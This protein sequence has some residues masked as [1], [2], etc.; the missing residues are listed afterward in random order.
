MRGY[1]LPL[2]SPKAPYMTEPVERDGGGHFVSGVSGNPAGRPR[3][4]GKTA[5]AAAI[6]AAL[7]SEAIKRNVVV[8]RSFNPDRYSDRDLKALIRAL[9]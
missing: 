1:P 9:R 2:N 3:G 7:R 5:K 8:D 4:R 6:F